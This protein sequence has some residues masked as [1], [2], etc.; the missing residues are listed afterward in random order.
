MLTLLLL[1]DFVTC[2]QDALF[3]AAGLSQ[4]L[5]NIEK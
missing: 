5:N 3:T 2:K 1:S 4:L